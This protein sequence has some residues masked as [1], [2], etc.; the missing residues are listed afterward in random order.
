MIHG[1]AVDG[2]DACLAGLAQVCDELVC[3]DSG[4]HRAGEA[5]AARHGARA[6][7]RRW[8]G[9][10][11]ARATAARALAGCDY[12]LFLDS[13]EAL[14]PGAIAALRRW[15]ASRPSA[16]YYT[17]PVRDWAT[18]RGR[19]FLFRV[20]RH[21]RLVR[22]D[23]ATWADH[24]IVHEA[25]PPA[26]TVR[27]DEVVVEHAFA[28]SCEGL[29]VK[30]DRY[31]LLW[32]LRY[33]GTGRRAKWPAVQ[34]LFH[35]LRDCLGKGA[36]LRGGPAAVALAWTV[37]RYHAQKY[38]YLEALRLG[39]L[40][41]LREAYARGQYAAVFGMVQPSEAQAAQEAAPAPAEPPDARAC[42]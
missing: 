12:V 15:R 35:A 7:A 2:L 32:A 26:P 24:M 10:G 6:V 30:G 5:I 20:E 4:R 40:P 22:A 16:P 38:V 8:E 37:A 29:A 19:R 11:A 42:R 13:D 17:I 39:A 36:L 25:L 28:S 34:R 41:A 27:L 18:L 21:V 23:H 14:T 31:A 1:D 9:Y 3:V 33:A